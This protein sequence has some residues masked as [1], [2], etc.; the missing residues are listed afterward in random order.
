[1]QPLVVQLYAHFVKLAK[2]NTLTTS[3]IDLSIQRALQVDGDARLYFLLLAE[4][5]WD[6]SH[7]GTTRDEYLQLMIALQNAAAASV[8]HAVLG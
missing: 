4:T 8:Q 1:M 7:A 3:V 6:G 5:S 2:A